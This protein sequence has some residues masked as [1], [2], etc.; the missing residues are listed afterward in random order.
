[1]GLKKLTRAPAGRA[2]LFS[3][4]ALIAYC[5]GALPVWSLLCASFLFLGSYG[6]CWLRC[7]RSGALLRPLGAADADP[8]GRRGIIYVYHSVRHKKKLYIER[9]QP[10]KLLFL[11]PQ[12][13]TLY[14]TAKL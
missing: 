8:A 5:S 9:D 3:R 2:L 6:V 12:S 7:A 14:E 11:T 4:P 13:C 1:M 10:K